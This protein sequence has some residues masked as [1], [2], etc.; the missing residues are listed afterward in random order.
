MRLKKVSVLIP[1]YNE[2]LYVEDVLKSLTALR[3]PHAM[4]LEIIIIDD[5]STDQ[6]RSILKKQDPAGTLKIFYLDKNFGKGAAIREGLK[7][8]TGEVVIIQ[9]ADL[10]YSI[11]DYPQLLEPFISEDAQAVYG[12]RFLGNIRDMKLVYRAFNIFMRFLVNGLFGAQITDEATAYKLVRTDVLRSLNL[13]SR[14][15]EICPEITAKL[16]RKNIPIREVPITYHARNRRQGK[17]ISWRD[18]FSA[19]F[20]LL[21]YRWRS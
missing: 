12:S 20:T 21:K 4:E 13:Q 8:A 11:A 15:F 17:K 14:R 6:T 19:I 16:L 2:E 3:L 1:V 7:H 5:G 10:E 9:D 18:A